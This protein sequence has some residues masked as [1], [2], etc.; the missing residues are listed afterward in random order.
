MTK[1]SNLMILDNSGIDY[2][3]MLLFVLG[4]VVFDYKPVTSKLS[5]KQYV[6]SKTILKILLQEIIFHS[7][8]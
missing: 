1:K 4:I 2:S 5:E 8:F 6:T 7:V 3:P